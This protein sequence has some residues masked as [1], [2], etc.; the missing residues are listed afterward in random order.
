MLKRDNIAAM[1]RRVPVIPLAVVSFLSQLAIVKFGFTIV[2]YLRSLGFDSVEIG[3][4]TSIYPVVYFLGCMILP[5][6]LKRINIKAR[7]ITALVGMAVSITVFSLMRTKALIYLTLF[8]YGFFQSLLWTNVETWI[9]QKGE[10]KLSSV[11]TLFNFSWSSSVGLANLLGGYLVGISYTLSFAVESA[12][13]ITAA[14]ITALLGYRDEEKITE[15]TDSSVEE[16]LSP[17]RFVSWVGIF[18]I[19][20]GYSMVIV[21]FP[22]YAL[23]FLG[24]SSS[25]SGT[26][27][28]MRGVSVC[29]AFLILGRM[30]FWKKGRL[31][32]A[33]M[34]SAFSVITFLFTLITD[35][36]GYAA[37]FIL[38]GLV[39]ALGYELSIYHSA[40]GGG[41]R[42]KRMVVHEVLITLGQVFGSF[43]GSA[44]YE[45]F[46]FRTLVLFVTAVGALGVI[47]SL[48]P[49]SPSCP[50][51]R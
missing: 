16:P 36:A 11:L 30:N 45:Y 14:V 31:P 10:W 15:E 1:E 44:L 25:E 13:F 23:D 34:L 17:Y 29:V 49:L 3:V 24:L 26:L 2:Y 22:Q 48:I 19:Y 35:T 28:F 47:F 39:F 27:L 46:S 37:V 9:T 12:V 38:Y 5:G 7:V 33:L 51:K 18:I 40:E 21:V 41:D 4:A 50:K 32:I 6:V 8:L 42:H 20:T 43:V